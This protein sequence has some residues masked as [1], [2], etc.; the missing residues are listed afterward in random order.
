VH[1]LEA[2]LHVELCREDVERPA[3]VR[4]DGAHEQHRLALTAARE[5]VLCAEAHLP[6]GVG[7]EAA[8]VWLDADD[9]GPPVGEVVGLGE[10]APDV[11]PRREQLAGRRPHSRSA[12]R[13]SEPPSMR[14]SSS[15]RSALSRASMRVWVGSPGTF[16]TRKWRSATLAIWGRCVIV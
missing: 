10:E 8:P 2:E 6:A 9:P 3:L 5:D 11:R 15:R 7:S 16:S 4:L 14:S 1:R 12:A 13:N